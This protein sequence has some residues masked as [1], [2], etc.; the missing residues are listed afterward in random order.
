MVTQAQET[1]CPAIRLN[2][3]LRWLGVCRLTWYAR[4]KEEPKKPGR[5]AK[6]VPDEL[7]G[8]VRKFADQFPWWGYK[9]IAIIRGFRS[10]KN[11]VEIRST[12]SWPRTPLG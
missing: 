10:T 5:K 8:P 4:R 2:H 12:S 9:R 11:W 1:A 7:A 3:L 6:P